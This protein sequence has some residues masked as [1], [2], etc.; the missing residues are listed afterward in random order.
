MVEAI[1]HSVSIYKSCII[2][3]DESTVIDLYEQ[4]SALDHTVEHIVLNCLDIERPSYLRALEHFHHGSSRMLIMTYQVWQELQ[5]LL[6]VYIMDADLLVLCDLC[7]QSQRIFFTWCEDAQK[8][9]YWN[10]RGLPR[11]LITPS[12]DEETFSSSVV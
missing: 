6:D 5:E 9:G 1:Y 12:V 3:S 10:P 4:F 2:C 8:R 11:V 7:S